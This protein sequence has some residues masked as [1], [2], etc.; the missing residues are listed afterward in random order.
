MWGSP[1][2]DD[3]SQVKLKVRSLRQLK[4]WAKEPKCLRCG[5]DLRGQ[6]MANSDTCSECGQACRYEDLVDQIAGQSWDRL[7][8]MAEVMSGAYMLWGL[9]F[10][11]API[12]FMVL[13]IFDVFG[14]FANWLSLLLLSLMCLVWLIGVIGSLGITCRAFRALRGFLFWML[15]HVCAIIF[16]S[17][18]VSIGLW[19]IRIVVVIIYSLIEWFGVP[20]DQEISAAGWL[21]VL[22]VLAVTMLFVNRWWSSRFIITP[23]R[24]RCRELTLQYLGESDSD[25]ESTG[26]PQG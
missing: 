2:K 20:V 15:G 12:G 26:E 24:I 17:A 21:H 4:K 5:Y 3:K 22:F 7:P 9:P 16:V 11:L 23:C 13:W 1:G 25:L 14:L 6:H 19:V 18:V 8:V 10:L